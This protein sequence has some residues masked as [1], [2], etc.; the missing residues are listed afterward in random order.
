MP[1]VNSYLVPK[2]R[3]GLQVIDLRKNKMVQLAQPRTDDNE[4]AEKNG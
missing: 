3:K 4:Q 1:S 2:G